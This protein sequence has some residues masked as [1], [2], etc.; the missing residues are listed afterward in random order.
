MVASRAGLF[1]RRMSPLNPLDTRLLWPR[2][3]P[4]DVLKG[5]NVISKIKL[6][7]MLNIDPIC[8]QFYC[9]Y[10]NCTFSDFCKVPADFSFSHG[11]VCLAVVLK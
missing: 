9:S 8:E 4:D 5:E 11:A 1:T 3:N 7:F 6:F 2:A 10:L